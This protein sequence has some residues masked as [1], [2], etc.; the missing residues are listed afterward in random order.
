MYAISEVLFTRYV[1]IHSSSTALLYI[2]FQV[3]LL[4][5]CGSLLIFNAVI[6]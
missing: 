1:Y 2:L 3:L 5:E 6:L 4:R